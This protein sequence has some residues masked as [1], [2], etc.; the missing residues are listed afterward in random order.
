M[1]RGGKRANAGRKKG[2]VGSRE[3]IPGEI[4]P[5]PQPVEK[6]PPSP[7]GITRVAV[8]LTGRTPLEVMQMAMEA[9]I[10]AKNLNKAAAVAKDL[11]PYVHPRKSSVQVTGDMRIGRSLEELSDAELDALI[12]A[13]EGRGSLPQI[14]GGEISPPGGEG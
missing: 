4:I 10:E 5:G 14:A 12:A 13:R 8:I 6:P 7:K 11:A 9:H 1:P 2:S 3:R